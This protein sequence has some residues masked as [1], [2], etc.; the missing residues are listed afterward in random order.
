MHLL[1]YETVWNT[2][3]VLKRGIPT[4]IYGFLTFRDFFFIIQLFLVLGILKFRNSG[5]FFIILTVLSHL[6]KWTACHHYFFI[7]ISSTR[8][9]PVSSWSN[10]PFLSG[11]DSSCSWVFCSC[12]G[13]QG[14]TYT[15]LKGW[16]SMSPVAI[17]LIWNRVH[18][19]GYSRG[20]T[21]TSSFSRKVY[22]DTS[23]GTRSGVTAMQW[24]TIHKSK[25][26]NVDTQDIVT[27]NQSAIS[28]PLKTNFRKTEKTL[29]DNNSSL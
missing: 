22:W 6:H 4:Q 14:E 25:H 16:Q 26:G 27:V 1:R 5:I 29:K 20:K 15:Q 7:P 2:N 23:S 13:L 8:C 19:G 3:G 11:G 12:T 17:A 21:Q 9:T 10:R 18:S 28:N 24:N